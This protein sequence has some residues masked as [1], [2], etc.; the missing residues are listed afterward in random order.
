MLHIVGFTSEHGAHQHLLKHVLRVT[1]QQDPS[2]V[3]D[4]ERWD[5]LIADPPLPPSV[6]A[7]RR[8]ALGHLATV[9]GCAAGRAGVTSAN[10]CEGCQDRHAIRVVTTML[11]PQLDAYVAVARAAIEAAFQ[12]QARS[13]PRL[14]S[15]RE[16]GRIAVETVDPAHVR[17]IVGRN[18]HHPPGEFRIVTCY[19][20]AGV[21]LRASMLRLARLRAAHRRA[22][23]LVTVSE[24]PRVDA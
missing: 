3:D 11:A 18:D 6:V 15:Y 9:T 12:V 19:R 14:V 8:Y 10:P 5:G 1:G 23:T 16:T 4:P 24:A 13:G 21:S 7:R 22:G 17:V 2:R 20:E